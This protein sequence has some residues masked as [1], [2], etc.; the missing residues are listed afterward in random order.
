MSDGQ[1]GDHF[2]R[3]AGDFTVYMKHRFTQVV[4]IKTEVSSYFRYRGGFRSGLAQRALTVASLIWSLR[5][6]IEVDREYM[7]LFLTG[8]NNKVVI[9]DTY[10]NSAPI[11]AGVSQGCVLCPI[12]LTY[13]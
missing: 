10:T 2:S 4:E 7:Q 1:Y 6:I 9:D 8:L 5:E 13:K 12:L 11:S 3:L